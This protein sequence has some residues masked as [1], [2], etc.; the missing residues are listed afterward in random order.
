M[1]LE[2]QLRCEREYA[3]L[4]NDFVWT[5]DTWDYDGCVVL[6]AVDGAIERAGQVSRGHT[7]VRLFRDARPG[8]RVTLNTSCNIRINMQGP[9]KATGASCATMFHA[10]AERDAPLPL[11]GS[12]PFFAEYFDDY[13]LTAGGWKIDHRNISGA[14][15]GCV[16]IA[17]PRLWGGPKIP[18]RSHRYAGSLPVQRGRVGLAADCPSAISQGLA[19]HQRAIY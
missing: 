2:E 5:V 16:R 17:A 15:T 3:R 7:G 18:R 13:V 8:N 9:A 1:T 10:Q 19:G 4:C 6:F 12:T 14:C 11:Q